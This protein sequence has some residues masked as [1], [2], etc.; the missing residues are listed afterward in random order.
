VAGLPGLA[1][2]RADHRLAAWDIMQLGL[3]D[4]S[5]R[6]KA[7]G[8]AGLG[9]Y[10]DALGVGASLGRLLRTEDEKSRASVVVL[11]HGYGSAASPRLQRRRRTITLNGSAFTIVGVAAPRFGGTYIV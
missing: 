6:P 5:G 10:F 11:G 4:G 3:R 2:R 9:N 7:P 1:R 8:H